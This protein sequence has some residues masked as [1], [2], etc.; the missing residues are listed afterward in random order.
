MVTMLEVTECLSECVNCTGV[1]ENQALDSAILCKCKCHQ[2]GSTQET[3]ENNQ[4][5]DPRHGRP[6]LRNVDR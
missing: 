3:T 2:N 1:Y 5:S 4:G 6:S